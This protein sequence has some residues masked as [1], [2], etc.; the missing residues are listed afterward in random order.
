MVGVSVTG[1]KW[2]A[3]VAGAFARCGRGQLDVQ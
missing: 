3:G 1:L 2:G